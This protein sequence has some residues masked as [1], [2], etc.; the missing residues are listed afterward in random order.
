MRC[1]FCNL[2]LSVDFQ[3]M[4]ESVWQCKNCE[5]VFLNYILPRYTYRTRFLEEENNNIVISKM[6]IFNISDANI[7]VVSN[8]SP[9][10]TI[11]GTESTI[12]S[13]P[14]I[15]NSYLLNNEEFAELANRY[16]KMLP[17]S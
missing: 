16:H 6:M 12:V 3:G 17:F 11:V 8:M 9:D 15:I 2:D 1:Y 4:N 10:K 14:L 13:S 5:D 7:F